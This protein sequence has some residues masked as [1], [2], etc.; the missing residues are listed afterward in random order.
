MDRKTRDL[1]RR[2]KITNGKRG[3][4]PAYESRGLGRKGKPAATFPTKRCE[5]IDGGTAITI[6]VK[7]KNRRPGQRPAFPLEII[8]GG[9]R[10]PKSVVARDKC[11]DHLG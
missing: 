9:I 5:H 7:R 8:E 10:C 4:L 3:E 1:R 6:F 2:N 11:L